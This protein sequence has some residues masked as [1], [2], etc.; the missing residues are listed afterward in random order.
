MKN[1]RG[2]KTAGKKR[3]TISNT[4]SVR[5]DSKQDY[6]EFEDEEKGFGAWLR[7]GDGVEWMRLFVIGNSIAVFLTMTWPHMQSTAKIIKEMIY[8]EE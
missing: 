7:S 5:D 8:G 1:K 6:L 4:V 3:V 2:G